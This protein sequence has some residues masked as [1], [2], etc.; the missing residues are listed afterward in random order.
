M[1][2]E[3][4]DVVEARHGIV[5]AQLHHRIGA[6]SLVFESDRLHRSEQQGVS[7]PLCHDLKRHASLEVNLLFKVVQ[8]CRLCRD[9]CFIEAAELLLRHRA[10]D[11]IGVALVIARLPVGFGEIDRLR[12]YDRGRRIKE[13]AVLLIEQIPDRIH[14]CIAGQWAGGDDAGSFRNRIRFLFDHRDLLTRPDL[15]IDEG[16]K[17]VAVHRQGTAGG[18]PVGIGG[19]H[20]QRADRPHL[21]FQ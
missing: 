6:L 9:Q 3:T 4:D 2:L 1:G 16:G 14:Q 5:L 7:A 12:R 8:R 10:V 21:L 20:D 17:A 15:L 11:I 13:I 19:F 18:N